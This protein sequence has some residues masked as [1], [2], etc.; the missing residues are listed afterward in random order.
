MFSSSAKQLRFDKVTERL[1][2]GT[3]LKH[4][5]VC[6]SIPHHSSRLN[7]KKTAESMWTSCFGVVCPEH[8]TIQP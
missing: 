2:V 8:W 4:N 5:V 6:T 7:W 1:K 3:F